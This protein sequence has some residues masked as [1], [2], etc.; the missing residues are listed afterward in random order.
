M[1]GK[2]TGLGMDGL[3]LNGLSLNGL[4]L[5]GLSL[6]GLSLNGLSLP[7]CVPWTRGVSPFSERNSFP[8]S[9]PRLGPRPLCPRT[10]LPAQTEAR[11]SRGVT[12]VNKSKSAQKQCPNWS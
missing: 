10:C 5:N 6:N 8:R 11:L 3:G 4:S 2:D 12:S 7:S 9:C 1:P